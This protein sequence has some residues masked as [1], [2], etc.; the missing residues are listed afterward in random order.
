MSGF[1]MNNFIRCEWR[2]SLGP[3]EHC[4]LPADYFFEATTSIL[5]NTYP[6]AFCKDHVNYFIINCGKLEPKPVSQDQYLYLC[7]TE[8]K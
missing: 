1:K 2:K 7:E 6:A 8:E 3:E 4:K 5:K